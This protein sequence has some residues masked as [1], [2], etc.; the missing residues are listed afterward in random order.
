MGAGVSTHSEESPQPK[1]QAKQVFA[2][3]MAPTVVLQ[4]PQVT[5]PNP[6]CLPKAPTFLPPEGG[7][8]LLRAPGNSPN[9]GGLPCMAQP[10]LPPTSLPSQGAYRPTC[11]F[12]CVG[13][14]YWASRGL[15]EVR[16]RWRGLKSQ[17]M[18]L[19][20]SNQQFSVKTKGRSV[21]GRAPH[22]TQ[23]RHEHSEMSFPALS[24]P[25]DHNAQGGLSQEGTRTCPS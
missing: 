5:V 9:K 22:R 10:C 16:R 21:V 11:N 25:F 19:A 2:V 17:E 1:H 12:V 4:G 6:R 3:M 18:S 24:P 7:G 15:A 13:G 23:L 8:C 20:S 14:G